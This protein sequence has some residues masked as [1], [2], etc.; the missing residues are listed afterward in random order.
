M[1]MVSTQLSSFPAS[2]SPYLRDAPIS[3]LARA[4]ATGPC[5][6]AGGLQ[7]GSPPA[8]RHA[9]AGKR[10]VTRR[11]ASGH[12]RAPSR[13]GFTRLGIATST[14]LTFCSTHYA[15]ATEWPVSMSRRSTA[16]AAIF[17]AGAIAGAWRTHLRGTP[18]ESLWERRDHT[19]TRR[20]ADS[21]F[22]RRWR[23][24]ARHRAAR[25]RLL[26]CRPSHRR[27]SGPRAERHVALADPAPAAA[28]A[29][30]I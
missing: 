10:Y 28:G 14:R 12:L 6:A 20:F 25:R 22:E 1:P 2:F 9:S 27:R 30:A 29:P 17:G 11:R 18:A 3:S 13:N 15:P 8:S 5:P 16:H 4:S 23:A 21:G 24:R 26:Q 7:T 19:R